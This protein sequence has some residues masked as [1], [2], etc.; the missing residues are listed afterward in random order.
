MSSIVTGRSALGYGMTP[1]VAR[2]NF[3]CECNLAH[4]M[5]RDAFTRLGLFT[6]AS[7]FPKIVDGDSGG[8]DHHANQAVPRV[9]VDRAR[10]DKPFRDDEQQD[11]DGIDSPRVTSRFVRIASPK[12]KQTRGRESEENRINRDNI[13]QYLFI[14]AG[15]RDDNRKRALKSDRN[16]RDAAAWM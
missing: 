6:L 3:A 16:R 11:D 2:L 1:L 15:H 13:I 4:S 7:R 12:R 10:R 5:Y 8:K 14:P 9:L